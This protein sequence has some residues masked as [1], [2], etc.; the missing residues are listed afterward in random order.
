LAALGILVVAALV[1]A[2]VALLGRTR[3][4]RRLERAQGERLERL[5]H[6]L[7][8]AAVVQGGMLPANNET[9]TE[10]VTLYGLHRPADRCSGDWW[11]H[12]D[13]GGDRHFVLVGDVTGH[14]PAPAL[15]TAA[16]AA[17]IRAQRHSCPNLIDRLEAVNA[18]VVRVGGGRFGLALTVVELDGKT[19]AFKVYLAGGMPVL[20]HRAKG[21]PA[22]ISCRSTPMGTPAYGRPTPVS[23]QLGPGDRLLLVTD[24]IPEI[25]TPGGQVVGMRRLL[26]TLQATAMDPPREA[27]AALFQGADRL[28][29]SGRQLDDWTCVVVDWHPVSEPV[30]RPAPSGVEVPPVP[31][32][33]RQGAA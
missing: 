15:V 31:A 2:I 22:A 30:E 6:E 16:V 32:T 3:T 13:D 33:A 8:L 10:D 14:G 29:A 19:G 9:R 21:R 28:Q 24:G 1:T 12:E 17:A 7:E 26:E 27:A 4:L 20:W 23:G 18:E 25:A 11:W 5:E